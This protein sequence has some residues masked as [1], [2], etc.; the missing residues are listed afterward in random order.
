MLTFKP[1]ILLQTLN[2]NPNNSV[3]WIHSR[4]SNTVNQNEYQSYRSYCAQYYRNYIIFSFYCSQLIIRLKNII[5]QIPKVNDKVGSKTEGWS[6]LP[7]V[8]WA[9]KPIYSFRM[10]FDVE[11]RVLLLATII[12]LRVILPIRLIHIL[13]ILINFHF[14]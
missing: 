6:H 10:F 1:L 8:G 4:G 11:S 5:C 9:G 12:T 7:A 13:R 14:F 3:F 2:L